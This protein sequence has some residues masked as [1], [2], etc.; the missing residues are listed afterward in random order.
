MRFVGAELPGSYGVVDLAVDKSLLRGA[1]GG[2]FLA[3][4]RVEAALLGGSDE[5]ELSSMSVEERQVFN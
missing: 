4:A 5:P 3:V 1:K 2:N